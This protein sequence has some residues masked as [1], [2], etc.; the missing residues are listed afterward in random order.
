MHEFRADIA[1][2]LACTLGEGPVWWRDCLWCVDIEGRALHRFDPADGAHETWSVPGR[3][4]FA[5]PTARGDWLV[6][7]D[8]S[9]ASFRPGAGPPERL[10]QI[11]ADT[12]G[13]RLNDAKADP[14]G[15]LFAGTMHLDATPGAGALYRVNDLSAQPER[16]VGSVTISNGLAWQA[17][18][19]TM[20]YIDTPTGRIDAFEWCA[21]T[22]GIGDRRPVASPEGGSPDGMCIDAEGLLWVAMWG[23][24]RV[25]RIDPRSGREVG[26]VP[27]PCEHVTS[28]CFGGPQLD[29]LWIT[30]A[31]AGLDNR[32]LLR[33]PLAGG[34]FVADVGV[35]G[36]PTVP[37][38]AEPKP[39]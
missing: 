11:E 27:L 12:G 28:C 23:G 33:Q 18:T 10:L 26:R 29:Q 7:Q 16:V 1:L 36:R 19:G 2:D 17:E 6:A 9:I 13:T 5:V 3:I 31:R 35:P 8:A 21:D 20:Y 38:A 37:V 25:S 4:G 30:T 39:G 14:T 24:A 22:G 34:L 32:S 15:R